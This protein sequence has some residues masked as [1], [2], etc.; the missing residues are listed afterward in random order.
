M[1]TTETIDEL[2]H[3]VAPLDRRRPHRGRRV[4]PSET[5]PARSTP[6]PVRPSTPPTQPQ[7]RRP[8]RPA[9]GPARLEE[10]LGGRVLAWVGAIA[11]LTGIFFRLVIAVSRGWIGEA[12]RTLTA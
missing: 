3:R 4:A 12:E 11:F 2:E 10:L 9:L 5:R 1:I 6:R 8:A 7:V